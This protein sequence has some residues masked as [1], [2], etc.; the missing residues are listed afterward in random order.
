MPWEPPP[1]NGLSKLAPHNW[2]KG[3]PFPALFYTELIAAAE[4]VHEDR[5]VV[6]AAADFD[7]RELAENWYLA[8]RRARISN[9]LLYALD[10]EAAAHFVARAI[11]TA[12]GTANLNAWSATRL[13]RHLQRALAERHM[14]AAALVHGGFDVLLTDVSAVLL[15]PIAPTLRSLSV[16]GPDLYAQ[17]GP[18]RLSKEPAI[19]CSFQWNLL[20]ARGNV[21]A[22]R[23]AR[24]VTFVQ[25]AIDR[26]MVD[27]YLRWWAGHHCIFMGY[28]KLLR[29][30]QPQVE[31]VSGAAATAEANVA[32][33]NGIAVIR[34]R[35]PKWCASDGTV[36]GTARPCMR[37]GQLPADLFP[38]A[39][40]FPPHRMHAIIGRSARP[41]LDPKR[42]HRL[43]LDRYDDID[44]DNLRKQM[45]SDG[46][47]LLPKP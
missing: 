10:A 6:L 32:H 12:N 16:D 14:A 44:F 37:L 4:R 30:A 46:L 15:R 40:D 7:F 39:G 19:G 26:G 33:P 17:R 35:H 13:Q 1:L 23:R 38:L 25:A 36:E 31:S 34:L 11:P 5:V 28:V 8:A 22:P 21:P 42:S 9:A 3:A 2:A 43:R 45:V 47:W 29:D 27:F 24:V 18:C 41:D 20:F